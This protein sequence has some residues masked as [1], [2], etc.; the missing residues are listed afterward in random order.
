MNG[1]MALRTVKLM[2]PEDDMRNGDGSLER[3]T[4]ESPKRVQIK[5]KN[6]EVIIVNRRVF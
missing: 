6:N 4:E 5:R 3:I 2:V 1:G